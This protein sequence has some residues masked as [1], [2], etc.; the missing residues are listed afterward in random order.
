[1]HTQTLF[2]YMNIIILL[3]AI[4]FIFLNIF[5]II[6]FLFFYFFELHYVY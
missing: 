4:W 6:I 1:M 5:L 2:I 3:F